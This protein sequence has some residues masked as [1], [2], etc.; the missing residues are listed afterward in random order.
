MTRANGLVYQYAV[1]FHYQILLL[2]S[3]Q[4]ASVSLVEENNDSK[5]I[6][7]SQYCGD[8]SNLELVPVSA[9][10]SGKGLPYAPEN[11][12]K[13]G[14][15]WNWRVGQRVAR[16]GHHMDRYSTSY[17]IAV[18]CLLRYQLLVFFIYNT[19]K[20]RKF[21]PYHLFQ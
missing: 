1:A 19:K 13:K 11:W 15:V 6:N 7:L 14:D 8:G 12:P 10:S 4:D 21:H 5:D 3:V 18:I 16:S 17:V 2:I 9:G 20:T